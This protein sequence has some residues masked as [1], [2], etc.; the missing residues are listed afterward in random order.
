M[1]INIF[2]LCVIAAGICGS[3]YFFLQRLDRDHVE[4]MEQSAINREII[5][6]KIN[7]EIERDLGL[8]ESARWAKVEL[9][10]RRDARYNSITTRPIFDASKVW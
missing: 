1:V 2:L 3:F 8:K 4:R 5:K 6:R 7:A 9:I 10:K